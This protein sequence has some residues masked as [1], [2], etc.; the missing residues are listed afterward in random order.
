MALIESPVL[1]EQWREVGRTGDQVVVCAQ[2]SKRRSGDDWNLW[3]AGCR[4]VSSAGSR[5]DF[6][7]F[8][9]A[10]HCPKHRAFITV[11]GEKVEEIPITP[12]TIG[13]GI[14]RFLCN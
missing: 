3:A 6:I 9:A 5:Y 14:Y 11:E 2:D 1:A 7:D 13:G 10:S 4:Y 8:A 12:G